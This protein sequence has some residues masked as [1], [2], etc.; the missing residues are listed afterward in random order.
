[1]LVNE[2]QTKSNGDTVYLRCGSSKYHLLSPLPWAEYK[3]KRKSGN[4]KQKYL[5]KDCGRQFVG[6]HNLDCRGCHSGADRLVWQMTARCCGIRDI[7]SITGYSRGKVQA[8]VV[9]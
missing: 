5:C 3:A 8:A 4:S 7:C 6:D 9:S 2:G 1:M